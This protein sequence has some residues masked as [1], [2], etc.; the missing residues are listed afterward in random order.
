MLDFQHHPKFLEELE[1][2][3]SHSCSGNSSAD[4]TIQYHQNLLNEQF[5]GS[6]PV[7]T[8]KHM[9]AAQGFGAYSVYWLHMII[10]EGKL[11]RTQNPKCYFLKLDGIISFLCL[12]SHISDYKDSKLRKIA[13]QRLNDILEVINSSSQVCN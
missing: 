9:G 12:D 7:Y 10:P 4:L 3:V 11:T 5:C 6:S 8:K 13:N 1:S 2:F